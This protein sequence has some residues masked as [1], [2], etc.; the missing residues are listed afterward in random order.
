M[1]NLKKNLIIFLY[2]LESELKLILTD[3]SIGVIKPSVAY[4]TTVRDDISLFIFGTQF[5]VIYWTAWTSPACFLSKPLSLH[6]PCVRGKGASQGECA[7]RAG[8]WGWSMGKHRCMFTSHHSD[9]P[10]VRSP[11]R[12]DLYSVLRAA[13]LGY[14]CGPSEL[15][16]TRLISTVRSSPHQSPHN[17]RMK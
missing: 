2:I 14:L 8:E 3:F 7:A 5:S 4:C 10:L 6:L 1:I 11:F 16:C 12:R 9:K 17:R 13:L 15:P